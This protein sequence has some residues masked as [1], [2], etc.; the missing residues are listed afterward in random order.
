MPF[1]CGRWAEY[2]GD[3]RNG[4]ECGCDANHK[5]AAIVIPVG[6][7]VLQLLGAC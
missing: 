7:L 3:K 1:P 2:D 6:R 4:K 5:G